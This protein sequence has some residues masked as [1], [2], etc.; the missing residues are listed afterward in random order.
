MALATTMMFSCGNDNEGM[1]GGNGAPDININDK[2][3]LTLEFSRQVI[4]ANGKDA[5]DFI[6]KVD[7]QQVTEGVT[8]Y[9]KDDKVVS[10]TTFTTTEPGEYTFWATYK[11]LHT[12]NAVLKAIS[13]A[14]PELPAD[15]TPE[16]TEFQKKI[17]LSQFTGNKC[18]NCPRMT[19]VVR[20]VMENKDIKDKV[21]FTSP[22][23]YNSTDPGYLETPIAPSFGVAS[24]PTMVF[25]LMMSKTYDFN[26]TADWLTGMINHRFAT[27]ATAGISAKSELITNDKGEKQIALHVAVKAAVEGNYRVGA[28]LLED[29]IKAKQANVGVQGDFDTHNNVVRIADSKGLGNAKYSGIDLGT[30]EA[31]KTAQHVFV[32]NL[33]PKWVEKNLHIAI[34]VTSK[35]EDG[36]VPVVNAIDCPIEC[37]LPFNYAK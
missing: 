33:N 22:H 25:D 10:S 37:D 19:V 1:D 20:Q 30:I 36:T 29:S 31:K 14:V 2:S 27:P 6:V 17:L 8:I 35:Q 13:I 21:V 15:P 7:G 34:F 12:K 24:Y 32:M 23:T 28:W 26:F 9:D 11:T 5:S 16:N 4:Q 18:P 3:K